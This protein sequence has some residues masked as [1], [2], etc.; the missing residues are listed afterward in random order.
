MPEPIRKAIVVGASSGIGAAIAKRLAAL[1]ATVAVV[2]RRE[3]ELQ[4]LC[5][6]INKSAGEERAIPFPHDV[7]NREEIPLLFQDIARRLDGL[8][9]IFYAAGVMPDVEPNEF[10]TDKD[11]LMMEVNTIGAMAWLNEGA[12][13]FERMG[14]GRLI[15]I[16]SI[17]GDRGRRGNPAYCTSKAALNT[18]LESLRNRLEVKGVSVTTIKPGFVDTVMTQGKPGLIWLISP[19]K[20]AE[21]IVEA[22]RQNKN[23]VYVPGQWRLV[24]TVIQSIPSFLF[25]RINI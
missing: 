13:R 3:D 21:R 9:A 24:G 15:G 6:E 20:A 2:A 18:F 23:I 10:S 14:S 25:K 19:E 1:G 12:K 16:S 17:A 22:A 7:R 5:E 4:G 8:D 11:A